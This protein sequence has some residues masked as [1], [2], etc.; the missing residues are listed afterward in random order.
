MNVTEISEEIFSQIYLHTAMI[1][2]IKNTYVCT[3]LCISEA[4]RKSFEKKSLIQFKV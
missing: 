2:Q 4:A 3:Y 1:N